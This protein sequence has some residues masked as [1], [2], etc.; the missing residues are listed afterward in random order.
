MA[1]PIA[2]VVALLKPSPSI[3]K[4]VTGGG[5][6]LVERKELGS[7]FY[8]AVV[9][10]HCLMT[11]TGREPMRLTAGDFV[12]VPEIF[13]FTMSSLQPPPRGVT[14]KRLETSP[15]AFRLGDPDVPAEIVAM[16]GHCAFGSD[17]KA[18]LVSLLPEVIHIRGEERLTLLV[19][20]INDETRADRT[21]RDMVL[22]RLLEVLLIE[23]LRLAGGAVVPPGLL[24]GMADP[25]LAP[26][27]RRIHEDPGRGMTVEALAQ[28]AAMSRSTFFERFRREVGVA[29]MEYATGWRMALAKEL[30]RKD[31]ATAEI[32]QRVGYGSA[33]AFSV[34]F[35]RHVGKPPGAYSREGAAA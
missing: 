4:L 20:M 24:R 14:A 3:S 9:D 11:I 2:E 25:L 30:L 13:S 21:A 16:V 6:W 29:P 28:A 32:A 18:L 19:R 26:A 23:A 35:T 10:G 5:R 15:G 1:D 22:R 7:P 27:L 17:D 12:L 31:V 33:S 8:C 34:A